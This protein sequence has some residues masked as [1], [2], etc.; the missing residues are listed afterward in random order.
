VK[1]AIFSNQKKGVPLKVIVIGAGI[2]GLTLAWSLSRRGHAVS[3]YE[4]GPIP[5]PI[6]SSYDEH[7]T[8]RHAYGQMTGYADLM[9]KA[10]QIWETLFRDLG[11]RHY[12]EVGIVYFMRGDTP[13]L[14][15]SLSSLNKN[16][17]AYRDV[18]LADIPHRFPMINPEGVT[19]VLE[20][21]GGGM[22]FPNRI[23]SD[24]IALLGRRGVGLHAY[25]KVGSIDPDR[26][27]IT[28][29][30]ETIGAD[31]VAV[32]AGAW[33]DRLVPD[34]KPHVVPSR[35]AVIYMAPP[36]ELAEAWSRAPVIAELSDETRSYAL[37]PRFG[38]RLKFGN[39][40]FTRR[41]DPDAAR[42]AS[43]DDLDP[44]RR[45]V[46][47]A[48][49]DFDRYAELERKAC[50]YTVEDKEQFVVRPV[51][52][53]AWVV[54]ACSGHGFKLQPL[55]TDGLARAIAGECDAETVTNWAAARSNVDLGEV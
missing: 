52:S 4:Q 48:F 23:M 9:P 53:S 33:V 51:G 36:P 15:P 44:V 47:R 43:H 11:R 46:R 38:T 6:A 35:Q 45:S 18:R 55:I 22:L 20:T 2:A 16:G 25:A 26:A 50:Y 29:G 37:P 21:E 30:G 19:H 10:Y 42:L 27:T 14:E 1:V 24:L 40:N 34:L 39:H 28:V 31:A 49:R 17:I 3:V 54:S 12:E 41:G 32:A 13:W 5:N 7:R 8:T